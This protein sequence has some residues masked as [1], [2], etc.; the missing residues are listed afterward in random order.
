[1]KKKIAV[2]S[3]TL[4]LLVSHQAYA[5]KY[6]DSFMELGVSARALAMANTLGALDSTETAFFSNPAGLAYVKDVRIGLMY[7]SL[8]GL[9]N[10]NYLGIA[11][12]IS[13]KFSMSASWIRFGVDDI[14][15]NPDI[16]RYVSDPE[17][18]RDSIIALSN[19]P[20][21]YFQDTEDAIFISFG[22]YISK[23]INLGW[24]Y[25]KFPIEIP[26]G[27]NFK[28]IHKDLYNIEAYGL[29]IDIGARIR[30]NGYDVVDVRNLGKVS[31]G[32]G[33]RDVTGTTIYW[34]TKSQDKIE[35]GPVLSFAYEQPIDLFDMKLNIAMEKEYRYDDKLRYGAE[36]VFQ[37]I[38]KIRAGLKNSGLIFGLGLNFKVM[39]R[40]V[41]IDYTFQNHDLGAT[42]RIGGGVTL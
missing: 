26:L 34:N 42:H 41:N 39:N 33:L 30:F 31:I 22:R 9:A 1:V 13:K 2:L 11:F 20:K 21:K 19:S 17:I 35:I 14:P 3:V 32:F 12:P 7:T 24:R 23:I 6:A 27:V 25:Q 10:H 29:G 15:L 38:L 36:I 8:F 37:E 28:I 40:L 16:F 18:R 5:G 4:F